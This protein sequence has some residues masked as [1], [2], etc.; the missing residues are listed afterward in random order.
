MSPQIQIQKKNKPQFLY[1][2][3]WYFGIL[4]HHIICLVILQCMVQNKNKKPPLPLNNGL[5]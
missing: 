2:S 3:W 4:Y 1:I 5:I